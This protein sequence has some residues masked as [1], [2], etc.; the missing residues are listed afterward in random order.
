MFAENRKIFSAKNAENRKIFSAENA[1]IRKICAVLVVDIFPKI[2]K[3]ECF[4]FV[5]SGGSREKTH[6]F[7]YRFDI[8]D[9]FLRRFEKSGK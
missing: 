3:I 2:P 4:L 1:E 9:R 6:S 7:T 8:F 5:I